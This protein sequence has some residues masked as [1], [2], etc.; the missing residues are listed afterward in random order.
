MSP[1]TSR[2][3]AKD[4]MGMGEMGRLIHYFYLKVK[5]E[6]NNSVLIGRQNN[7]PISPLPCGG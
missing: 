7:V 5:E 1:S 2:S 6:E 4:Y 3:H